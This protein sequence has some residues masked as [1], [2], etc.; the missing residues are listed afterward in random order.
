MTTTEA[1]FK[2]SMI[3]GHFFLIVDASRMARDQYLHHLVG[4]L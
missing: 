4:R 2:A 3:V 1:T